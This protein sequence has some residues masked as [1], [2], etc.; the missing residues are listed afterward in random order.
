M[1]PYTW[2]RQYDRLGTIEE[3]RYMRGHNILVEYISN[4]LAVDPCVTRRPHG[5]LQY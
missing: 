1:M 2:L 4:T 5:N 3:F